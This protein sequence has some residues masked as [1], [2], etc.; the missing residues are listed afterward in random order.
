MRCRN[1][2]D[3]RT[4]AALNTFVLID[5]IFVVAPMDS[6]RGAFIETEMTPDAVGTDP[7][8]N[9]AIFRPGGGGPPRQ[10]E[11]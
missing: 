6:G 9:L 3:F 5:D 2:T 1:I 4:G 8:D 10:F 7:I 11:E